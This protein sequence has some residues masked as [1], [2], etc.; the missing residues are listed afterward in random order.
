MPTGLSKIHTTIEDRDNGH[1]VEE[2]PRFW[3]CPKVDVDVVLVKK[4]S[5]SHGN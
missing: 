2:L 3:K 4:I 5:D 1:F